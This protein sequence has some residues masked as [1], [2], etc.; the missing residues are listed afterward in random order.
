MYVAVATRSLQIYLLRVDTINNYVGEEYN[1][2][3]D[4]NSDHSQIK[5]NK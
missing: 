5:A 4:D 3:D 2:K 1:E